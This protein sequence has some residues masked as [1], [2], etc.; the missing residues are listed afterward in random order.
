MGAQASIDGAEP[1][2]DPSWAAGIEHSLVA[3][4]P[5]VALVARRSWHLRPRALEPWREELGESNWPFTHSPMVSGSGRTRRSYCS[6]G[7]PRTIGREIGSVRMGSMELH[8]LG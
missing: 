4:I 6:L 3:R 8:T 7:P 2:P 1:C 5:T